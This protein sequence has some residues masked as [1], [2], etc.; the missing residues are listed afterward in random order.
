MK[1]AGLPM[2]SPMAAPYCGLGFWD[3][4]T[5][6]QDI[7]SPAWYDQRSYKSKGKRLPDPHPCDLNE[8]VHKIIAEVIHLANGFDLRDFGRA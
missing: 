6:L 8:R 1:S 7:R 5:K 2:D 4:Y 3:T